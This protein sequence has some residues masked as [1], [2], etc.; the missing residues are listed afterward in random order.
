MAVKLQADLQTFDGKPVEVTPPCY[1]EGLHVV[2][3]CHYLGSMP[4][5]VEQGCFCCS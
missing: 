5:V 4:N 3:N 2:K 1:F